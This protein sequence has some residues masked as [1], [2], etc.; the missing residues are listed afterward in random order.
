MFLG[1]IIGVVFP[2]LAADLSPYYSSK[3]E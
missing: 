1:F 3:N 2:V